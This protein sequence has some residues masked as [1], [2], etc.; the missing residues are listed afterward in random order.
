V[1]PNTWIALGGLAV[2]AIGIVV[3]ALAPRIAA[4]IQHRAWVRDKRA[5]A[6]V[7][8]MRI[9]SL[10]TEQLERAALGWPAPDPDFPEA[11]QIE[12]RVRVYGNPRVFAKTGE[13]IA[14]Y[15]SASPSL[16]QAKASAAVDDGKNLAARMEIGRCRERLVA[17]MSKLES[18]IRADLGT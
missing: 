16:L 9:F 14:T 1:N 10:R 12:A 8:A 3:G 5:D 7:D 18:L 6:Y 11:A 13:F 17:L 2:A 4:D 15:L